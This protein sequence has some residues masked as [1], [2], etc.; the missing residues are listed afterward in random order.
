MIEESYVFYS[1]LFGAILNVSFSV[2]RSDTTQTKNKKAPLSLF[3]F[4][5]F[6]TPT[7]DGEP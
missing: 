3:L 5:Y 2:F 4:V 1:R 6:S 7:I